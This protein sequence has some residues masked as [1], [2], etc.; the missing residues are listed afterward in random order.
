[1][2]PNY[3]VIGAQK[4]ATSSVCDLLGQ[5]PDVF[6][7]DPKEPFFFSHDEVYARGLGWYESL[8]DAA[9]PAAAVGEGSTTYTQRGLYPRAAERVAEHLPGARLIYVVRDPLERI[10]SHWMHLRS[11][12]GRETL[13]FEQA[14]MTRPEY[15]D[16]S[17][18]SAQL[19]PYAPYEADGRLLVVFFEDFRADPEGELRRVFA[20][21]GVDPSAW[22]P[23]DAAGVRHRSAEGRADTPLMRPLRRVPGF[24]TLRDLAPGSAREA[25]R[26]I[27]KKPVG[28]RPEWTPGAR[29]WALERIEPDARAFLEKHGKPAGYWSLSVSSGAGST[30]TKSS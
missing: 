13:P 25:L 4:C 5:H 12:G 1:M 17:L 8:F 6:M 22:V 3:L 10:R 2:R 19:E 21:L 26:R 20:F 30:G 7:T 24:A 9:G 27:F 16:H 29:T 15:V 18:Y 23:E 28:D 14:V 11:K